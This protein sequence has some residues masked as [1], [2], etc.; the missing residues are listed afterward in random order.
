MSAETFIEMLATR[1]CFA[2]ALALVARQAV[3]CCT[4]ELSNRNSSTLEF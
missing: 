2:R 1:P 4:G 3:F